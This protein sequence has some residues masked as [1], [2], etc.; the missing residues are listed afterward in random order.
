MYTPKGS[1]TRLVDMYQQYEAKSDYMFSTE[2]Y[3][4]KHPTGTVLMVEVYQLC[5]AKSGYMITVEVYA[6]THALAQNITL[7]SVLLRICVNK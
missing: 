1:Y 2:V 3:A 5:E 4:G 6:S 7:L